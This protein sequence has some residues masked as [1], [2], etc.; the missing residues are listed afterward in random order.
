MRSFAAA[1]TALLTAIST[2]A[3][4][5][6]NSGPYL[7]VGATH[8]NISS[9]GDLKGLGINGLGAT[10]FAGYKIPYAENTFVSV[11]ANFDLAS[12]KAEDA[13]DS[14]KADYVYGGS[15]LL[16]ANLNANTSFYGRVGYQRGRETTVVNSVRDSQSRNGVRFGAGLEAAVSKKFAV[17]LEY[18]R[19]HY[20]LNDLDKAAIA[21]LKGGLNNDQAV[22]ALVSTF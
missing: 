20:Y 21:P 17:R 5:Q 2:P 15:V 14:V 1:L 11:E 12:A 13:G 22:L 6:S 18:N 4:A 10:V 8:D 7:G 16:G 3:L 19:T 9:S